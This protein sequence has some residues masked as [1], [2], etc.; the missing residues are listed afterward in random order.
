MTSKRSKSGPPKITRVPATRAGS[1]VF[2]GCFLTINALLAVYFLDSIPSPNPT[3]RVLPVLTLYEEHT[4]AIDKY[5]HL[6]MDKSHVNGHYYSDKAPLSTWV[7]LP[8]Y[9]LLRSLHFVNTGGETIKGYPAALLLGDVL[10]GSIPFVWTLWLILRRVFKAHPQV[11]PALLCM[12]PLYGS[13]IFAYAGVFMSH[14]L[15]GLLLLGSYR[16]LKTGRQAFLCGLLLG[17]AVLAEFPTVLALPIWIWV[18]ARSRRRDLGWF[19]L[20]GAPCALA[21]AFY[22]HTI[23]G[24][25]FQMPYAFE[26]ERAFSE[27]RSAYGM[28]W[29]SLEAVWGLVFS[30]YRGLFF[31]APALVYIAVRYF[32]VR[33]FKSVTEDVA[34]PLGL[35]MV[36]YITLM[37]SYFVWW[38]GWAYGPRHLIPLAMLL[39]YEGI[40]MVARLPGSRML[41]YVLSAI[42][43]GMAW[44]AKTTVL[45][46][47]PEQYSNPVFELALPSL[48]QGK[49]R[50]DAI[51]VPLLHLDPLIAASLWPALLVLGAGGLYVLYAR[52]FLRRA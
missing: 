34:T 20:G 4:Y 46:M 22:N 40:P 17:L 26:T 19:V 31:Y 23:T 36:C 18:M 49:V 15:S 37:S 16:L 24:S 12:L 43:I 39:M 1:V 8:A 50:P 9:A 25:Y 6:T 35:L 42:G 3:S 28:G 33:G 41:L 44:L 5:E 29:P 30:S 32:S 7:V 47:I 48:Q 14:V 27:M 10:C 21:L 11:N 45:Y 2:F 52:T 51:T 13:F 38:G